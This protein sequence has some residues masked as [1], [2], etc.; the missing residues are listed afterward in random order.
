[1]SGNVILTVKN[2]S[3]GKTITG[4]SEDILAMIVEAEMGSGYPLEALKAQVVA[5]YSYLLTNGAASG[6]APPVPIKTAES[7]VKEAVSATL[8]QK[9][10]FEG[11]VAQTCYY[12]ISAGFSANSQDIWGNNFSYLQSVDS[13]V[14]S[15][16]SG[17]STTRVYS[18]SDIASWILEEYKI[19]VQDIEESLWFVPEYDK[20]GLYCTYVTIGQQARVKGTD[21]KNY[22]FTAE[23]VG[24]GNLLRSSAYQISYSSASDNFIF[25]VKGY[26]HGVG[27]SQC[28]AKAY[29]NQGWTYTQILQHYYSGITIE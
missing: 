13:S 10:M 1:M 9:A 21:L 11:N 5:T 18:A 2:S 16:V 28:G 12:A 23:R 17:F 27:M 19:D 6:N 3:T 20:N 15:S 25:T 22:L 24:S 29:A 8:G 26:G 7:R 4:N 14:D